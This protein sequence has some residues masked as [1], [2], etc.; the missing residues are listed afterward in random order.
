MQP[1]ISFRIHLHA[2]LYPITTDKEDLPTEE[3]K[4]NWFCLCIIATDLRPLL[5]TWFD[6]NSSMVSNYTHF[7]VW[8]EIKYPFLNFNGCTVEV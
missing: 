3:E 7:N 6:F 5:L 2:L 1:I 4:C 8:G